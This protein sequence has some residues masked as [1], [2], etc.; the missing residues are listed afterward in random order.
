MVEF[1]ARLLGWASRGPACHIAADFTVRLMPPAC[2]A[3]VNPALV[4]APPQTTPSPSCSPSGGR[5]RNVLRAKRQRR[6]AATAAAV[7]QLRQPARQAHTRQATP[8][9]QPPQRRRCR[10][11]RAQRQQRPPSCRG[12][13]TSSRRPACLPGLPRRGHSSGWA[14]LPAMWRQ[15]AGR[16]RQARK[17]QS[18]HRTGCCCRRPCRGCTA[19]TCRAA[20]AHRH[21]CQMRRW[22]LWRSTPRLWRPPMPPPLRHKAMP[23]AAARGGTARTAGRSTGWASGWQKRRLPRCAAPAP[24]RWQPRRRPCEPWWSGPGLRLGWSHCRSVPRPPCQCVPPPPTCPSGGSC[25]FCPP[26]SAAPSRLRGRPL[27]RRQRPLPCRR[28]A[29]RHCGV[30]S[31]RQQLL[32]A[33]ARMRM[34]RTTWM[35]RQLP[36]CL[37]AWTARRPRRRRRR[38]SSGARGCSTR[39]AWP[40]TA[41]ASLPSARVRNQGGTGVLKGLVTGSG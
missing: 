31:L 21:S 38:S 25:T 6:R 40:R 29:G 28:A 27:P 19:A 2:N 14:A 33:A 10:R 41:A 35:W 5:Q 37:P 3:A 32:G 7:L 36:A 34:W 12:R 1:T 8:L 9:P 24:R 11:P 39:T 30:R 18:S 22:P 4:L 16:L 13:T 17:P 20:G 15:A 23:M 26:P